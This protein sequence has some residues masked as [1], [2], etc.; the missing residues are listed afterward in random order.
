MIHI[1]YGDGKGKTTAAC[2]LALRSIGQGQ[3]VLLTQFLKNDN[4]GEIL[5]FRTLGVKLLHTN[6]PMTFTWRM[7]EEQ[8]QKTEQA[9]R[10]LLDRVVE[11]SKNMD[12]VIMDEVLLVYMH[13]MIDRK[14]V[15]DFLRSTNQEIVLTGR[16][17]PD[18]D[19]LELADYVT[20]IKKIKH[21]FDKGVLERRGVEF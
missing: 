2:G 1:Y 21:P 20:E 18:E 12:L 3:H 8:F 13:D 14:K 10:N 19:L 15:L 4:S 17:K 11:E 7:N 5:P 6:Y 16:D 9:M